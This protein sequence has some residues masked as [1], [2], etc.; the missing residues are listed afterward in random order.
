M[1][2]RTHVS[3]EEW[4]SSDDD[5]PPSS[6]NALQHHRS[7]PK[8]EVQVSRVLLLHAEH[9]SSSRT[10]SLA[11]GGEAPGLLRVRPEVQGEEQPTEA[12]AHPRCEGVPVR[13]VPQAIWAEEVSEYA[14]KDAREKEVRM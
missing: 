9:D 7:P 3:D 1:H 11:F 10:R 12:P 5:D 6:Q 14:Q 2:E 8:M 4:E 13:N